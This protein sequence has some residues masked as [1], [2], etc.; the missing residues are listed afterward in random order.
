MQKHSGARALLSVRSFCRPNPLI[1]SPPT[2]ALAATP[3]RR[4]LHA[5]LEW[6]AGERDPQQRRISPVALDSRHASPVYRVTCSAA[7]ARRAAAPLRAA[8]GRVPARREGG[9][10]RGNRGG[11][12]ARWEAGRSRARDRELTWT[13]PCWPSPSSIL[14]AQRSLVLLLSASLSC[15]GLS[16]LARQPSRF[17]TIVPVSFGADFGKEPSVEPLAYPG[18]GACVARTP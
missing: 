14:L 16:R 5:A 18:G 11:G 3:L 4:T 15:L 6:A 2:N 7:R 10:A 17:V 1:V 13:C 8:T 12:Q 9:A